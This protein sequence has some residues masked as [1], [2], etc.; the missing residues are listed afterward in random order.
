MALGDGGL[1]G[2]GLIGYASEPEHFDGHD[3]LLAATV[4]WPAYSLRSTPADSVARTLRCPAPT[5]G[6]SRRHWEREE[7]GGKP[8]SRGIGGLTDGWPNRV[9]CQA[10]SRK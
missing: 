7:Q 10:D 8:T 3:I 6:Q 2:D 9:A 1:P 5:R 4:C